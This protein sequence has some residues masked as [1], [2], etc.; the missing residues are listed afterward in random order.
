MI[1]PLV[2][3]ENSDVIFRYGGHIIK[4]ILIDKNTIEAIEIKPRFLEP[5]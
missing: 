2:D 4:G 3:S 1:D 5:Q